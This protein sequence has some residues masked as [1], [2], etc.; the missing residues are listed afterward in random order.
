MPLARLGEWH[1]RAVEVTARLISRYLWTTASIDVFVDSQCVLQTG[2]QMKITGS[3]SAQ[4]YD[5]GATH[6][7][8]LHWDRGGVGFFPITVIIDGQ[9]VAQSRVHVDNWPLALWPFV[10]VAA[11]AWTLFRCWFGA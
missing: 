8:E 11:V 2:G 7:I 3:S 1:G 10:L 4:F 6:D 9:V 5:S